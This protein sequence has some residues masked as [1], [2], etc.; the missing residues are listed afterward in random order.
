MNT[1]DLIDFISN[2]EKKTPVEVFIKGDLSSIDFSKVKYFGNNKFGTIVGEWLDVE[3][4]LKNNRITDSHIKNDRRNS[5]VPMIDMK[6]INSRIE[7]GVFIRETAEIGNNCIIM[8]GSVINVGAVIGDETMIDL[9]VVVGGRALI[10][11]KCHIGAGSVIAG[12]IEP[13]SAQP[14]IIEDGVVVGANAVILEGVRIGK[15]AVVAAGAVVT[16]D[17]PEGM[18][19]AGTPAK[20][21]KKRD[22]KTNSKTALVDSLRKL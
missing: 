7:P 13:P 17:V 9:N 19:V 2:A 10:G 14:V 6:N 22:E 12:V 16:E 5:A 18:V 15:N 20:V 4:I 1:Q 21:I 3:S 8:M 11:K